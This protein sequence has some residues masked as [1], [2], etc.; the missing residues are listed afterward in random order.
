MQPEGGAW[1]WW[2]RLVWK[3]AQTRFGVW[4]VS[5]VWLLVQVPLATRSSTGCPCPSATEPNLG[6]EHVPA[7][8]LS[9]LSTA[10]PT[11]VHPQEGQA[12]C[13]ARFHS[14]LGLGYRRRDLAGGEV[15]GNLGQRLSLP[16]ASAVCG[17]L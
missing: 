13:L 8:A 5:I 14:G 17:S 9:A 3:I 7:S 2:P 1:P 11:P 10:A 15:Q 16:A 4:G 6:L 12:S